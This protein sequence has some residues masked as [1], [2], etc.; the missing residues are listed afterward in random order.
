MSQKVLV[1]GCTGMV[2]HG[3]TKTLLSRGFSVVGTARRRLIS[4]HENFTSIFLDLE[5]PESFHHL[6]PALEEIDY[7]VHTA[8]LI[9]AVASQQK[10]D[11]QKYYEV[12][13]HGTI[14]LLESIKKFGQAETGFALI[15]STA[16]VPQDVVTDENTLTHS[17]SHYATSK[18]AAEAALQSYTTEAKIAGAI[19]RIRAPYGFRGFDGAVIPLFLQKARENKDIVL[20]GSGGRKQR[21]TF[22]EDIAA[23][24]LCALNIKPKG[25]FNILGPET[26]TMA[27]LAEAVLLAVPD[28][29]SKIVF[30]D[31]PDLNEGKEVLIFD[32]IAREQLG[33][34]ARY[35][36]EEGLRAICG[37]DFEKD[38]F[39]DTR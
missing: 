16:L 36:I 8:G 25:V 34:K 14:R 6:E 37:F 30:H 39:N 28:T 7:I 23:A 2:G 1:T 4:R 5:S 35:K 31:K 3:V 15:S 10:C 26:I 21:F 20:W 24:V 33:F 29:S 12:N 22:V 32:T 27:Q 19:L 13:L 9:P 38:F 11:W 17:S 18:I